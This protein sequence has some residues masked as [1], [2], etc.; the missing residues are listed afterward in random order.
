MVCR[1]LPALCDRTD[2]AIASTMCG[3]NEARTLWIIAESLADLPNGH[4][5]NGLAHKGPRPDRAEKFLFCDELSRT[6]EQILEHGVGFGSELYR[7][8]AVPQA[9]VGKVQAKGIEGYT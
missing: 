9:L 4:F 1:R 7:L 2:K 8:C 5:Q 6:P 3:L